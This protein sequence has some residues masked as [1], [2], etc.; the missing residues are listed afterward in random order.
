M[1]SAPQ[2]I[3]PAP[4]GMDRGGPPESPARLHWIFI[5]S[6]GIRAGWR[7]LTA[8]CLFLLLTIIL[9]GGP[10]L[11]PFV[12]AWL[13]A[14]PK[15]VPSAGT[16]LFG[17]G[18]GAAALVIA[19]LIMSAIE[20]RS[21]AD[22]GLPLSETLGKRF[23]QGVL[24]GLPMISLLL[25]L[26]G[27]LHGFSIDGLDLHG[28][29]AVRYGAVYLLVFV[30]VGFFE[31]F[32]FR[33]YLQA[34]LSSALGFWPAAILLSICFGLLHLGNPGEAKFGALMAACFG[35]LAA[36]TLRRTGTIW[37]AI[38]MHAAWD[39]GETFFYSVPDS[40]MV[41][42]GHLMNSSFHGPGWLTGGT[43]GP[44][45]SVFVFVVLALAAIV[46]HFMFPARETAA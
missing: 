26:I 19:A 21:F 8:I 17:E 37:L 28:G 2:P 14:Q 7:A 15:H 45:A 9:Q 33:G 36:F 27:A 20:K 10:A 23:W 30:L 46:V 41:A 29:T 5:G 11:I 4:P 39:W 35:M 25:A 1:T 34:T 16:L 3:E 32:S 40:G 12:H 18:T 44:E 42:R 38:G 43:V 22:Y 24:Y 13:A 6:N 31:E